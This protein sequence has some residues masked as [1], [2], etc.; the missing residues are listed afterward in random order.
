MSR[1]IKA[2]VQVIRQLKAEVWL[3]LITLAETLISLDITKVNLILSLLYIEQ[4]KGSHV[5]A[6]L[7]IASNK[8]ESAQTW[9]DSP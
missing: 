4:K 7:L 6:S 1:V 3:R 5:F 9:H 2:E 8:T